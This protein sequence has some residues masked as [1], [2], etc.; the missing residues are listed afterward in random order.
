MDYPHPWITLDAHGVPDLSHAYAVNIGQWDK[1]AIDYGYRQFPIGTDEQA[2]HAALN[3]ILTDSEKTGLLYI[4]DEDARPFGGA[5]PHAHLWDNGGDPADELNRILTIRSAALSRFGLNAIRTGTPIAQLED[6]LAPLYLLHRYQT[7]ATIK[8]IGGLDYRY[9]LR[10]D[11]Q[12][13]PTLVSPAEQKKALDAVLKTLSPTFLTLPE[14]LLQ[15]LPPRPPGLEATRE[16]LPS[17]TGLT[18]DPIAAAES[19]ADLSLGVLFNPQRASRLVEYHARNPE[20]PSLDAVL[21][22]TLAAARPPVSAIRAASSTGNTPSSTDFSTPTSDP[23]KLT[24]AVQNA[25]YV[26]TVEALLTL[27]ANPAASSGARAIVFAKL[28]QIKRQARSSSPTDQYIAHR[29]QQFQT[30]PT[31]FIPAKPVD[32]P[33]G[34]PIGDTDAHSDD[35]D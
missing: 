8:E 2:E 16:S 29:I 24:A 17:D 19:A 27:A 11:G 9:Q 4:T 25:V 1:V 20:E 3:Q 10:D 30:D 34:M 14:P 13:S 35:E 12:L 26:R 5:H 21:D 18:F 32:A 22:L 7:E 33:P 6:T 23:A 31:K 15:L 28:D